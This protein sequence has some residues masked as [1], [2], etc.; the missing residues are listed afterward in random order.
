MKKIIISLALFLIAVCSY[1]QTTDIFP[2]RDGAVYYEKKQSVDS[3]LTK[4]HLFAL[5]KM[6]LATV[7]VDSREVILFDDKDAGIIMGKGTSKHIL[8]SGFGAYNI[9]VSFRL[10]IKVQ[11]GSYLIELKQFEASYI[12][13][14]T[15]QRFIPNNSTPKTNSKNIYKWRNEVN[16]TMELLIE[17][18]Y[19][20]IQKNKGDFIPLAPDAKV[21]F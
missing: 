3:A 18:L 19:R 1:S 16:Y 15:L 12:A 17:N 13:L 20:Y 21:E 9:T 6:W 14:N 4:E 11:K 7:F 2:L 10:A 5:S 8:K